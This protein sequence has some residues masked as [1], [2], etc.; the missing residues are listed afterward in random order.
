MTKKTKTLKLSVLL[1]ICLMTI[2]V[3]AQQTLSLQN[4]RDMALENNKNI[5]MLSIVL[6]KLLL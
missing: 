1:V 6:R 5:K 4:C 2:Q 3:G